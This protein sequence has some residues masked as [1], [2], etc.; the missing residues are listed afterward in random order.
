MTETTPKSSETG[1]DDLQAAVDAIEHGILL[2]G[3][4]LR[5]SIANKTYK[6]M[7]R[8]PEGL[9][10]KKPTIDELLQYIWCSGILKISDDDFE[11]Y[12]R[13]CIK[14]VEDDSTLMTEH[15]RMD[16]RIYQ[17]RCVALPNSSRMHICFDRIKLKLEETDSS[18]IQGLSKDL[19]RS[20]DPVTGQDGQVLQVNRTMFEASDFAEDDL[21]VLVSVQTKELVDEISD[22]KEVEAAL[23]AS[24][25][26]LR[27]FAR[28]SSDWFWEIDSDFRYTYVGYQFS[29]ITKVRNFEVIGKTGFEVAGR[30]QVS[31]NVEKWEAHRCLLERHQ[32]FRNFSSFIEGKDGKRRVIE[33]AGVPVFDATGKF[34]GY[35]GSGSDVTRI[36]ETEAALIEANQ[37]LEKRVKERTN[38][39]LV[40]KERAE[41]ANRAKTDFLAHMSHELRTPLNAIIGFSEISKDQML[42]EH[43]IPKYREYAE[44]IHSASSHLLSMISDI[45]DVSKVEAGEFLIEEEVVDIRELIGSCFVMVQERA[46]AKL[47]V[48]TTRIEPD[49]RAIYADQRVMKQILIN[50]MTNAIKFSP[51]GGKLSVRADI[52]KCG[53]VRVSV[54]DNGCG[55]APEHITRVQEAFAQVRGKSD[56]A[57]EGTGLGLALTKRFV[58]LHGGE[59]QIESKVGIGTSVHV[60]LPEDRTATIDRSRHRAACENG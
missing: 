7:W 42:G 15:E 24:E 21:Q 14:S 19:D 3:P 29:E 40:E 28:S 13:A 53:G 8:L 47:I 54:T 23:R 49:V 17:L 38:D 57:S 16:G 48:S 34:I 37:T 31:E 39:L 26:R 27:D 44:D 11:Q 33:I 45:L 59:L 20:A 55:I 52:R 36:Y 30:E 12:V 35:R 18:E 60:L 58:E 51:D 41:L 2:F 22:R 6:K 32:P 5:V 10:E 43:S 9:I 25:E 56:V 4:D 50:L 46:D 1:A